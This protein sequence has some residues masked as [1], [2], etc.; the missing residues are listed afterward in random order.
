MEVLPGPGDRAVVGVLQRRLLEVETLRFGPDVLDGHASLPVDGGGTRS[1]TGF[2]PGQP[3]QTRRPPRRRAGRPGGAPLTDTGRLRLARCVVEDGWPLRRAAERFQV[4]HTNA[5]RWTDRYRRFGVAGMSDRTSRPHHQPL[6]TPAET[7]EHLLR[8]RREHR[9]GPLR[10]AA[11][12][13]IAPST[14]HRILVRHGTPPLAAL[15]RATREPVRRY[16]RARPGELVHIDVKKLGRIP[17]GGGHK[18]L[19]RAAGSPHR[20]AATK[21]DTPTSTPHSTTTPASPTPKTCPTRPPPTCAAF[22]TRATAWFASLGITVERVLTDNAWAYSENTW[23]ETCRDLGISPRWTGPW[24]PQTNGKVERFH[25]TLLEEWA[26]HRPYTSDHQRQAAFTDWI[27]WWP[28]TCSPAHLRGPPP[29][30]AASSSTRLRRPRQ[31]LGNGPV[32]ADLGDQVRADKDG[33]QNVTR[34]PGRGEP[35]AR[36]GVSGIGAAPAAPT[37][38]P[39]PGDNGQHGDDTSMG[40]GGRTIGAVRSPG[41]T[42]PT[43]RPRE[44][45]SGVP[46]GRG[47]PPVA[48]CRPGGC[49]PPARD[50]PGRADSLRPGPVPPV[51]WR[52]VSAWPWPPWRRRGERPPSRR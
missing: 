29:A 44:G 10:L 37:A 51:G 6:R 38:V 19:G 34:P 39:D 40:R 30:P 24:R 32:G 15:D 5:S 11:R 22:L 21:R 46:D 1:G 45:G 12:C 14:A 47:P 4:S 52:G 42:T 43:R 20:T 27:N 28:S 25:R 13:G 7:E 17:E 48:P 9:I 2:A 26:Y 23:R 50:G 35:Y 49:P 31:R 3:F 8:L 16:E 18:V 36:P 41:G 33:V